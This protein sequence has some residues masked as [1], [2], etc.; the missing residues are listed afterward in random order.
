MAVGLR[1]RVWLNLDR[2]VDGQRPVCHHSRMAKIPPIHFERYQPVDAVLH[3]TL[4]GG[5][6]DSVLGVMVLILETARLFGGTMF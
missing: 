6:A 4:N 5:I 1:C 3:E 2:A